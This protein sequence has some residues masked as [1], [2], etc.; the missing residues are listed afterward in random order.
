M[1][2]VFLAKGGNLDDFATSYRCVCWYRRLLPPAIVWWI[3][4]RGGCHCATLPVSLMIH[5]TYLWYVCT[6]KVLLLALSSVAPGSSGTL[7]PP[8]H[9]SAPFH[10]RYH[11]Q[12]PPSSHRQ[13]TNLLP[14]TKSDIWDQIH[15]WHPPHPTFWPHWLAL[16]QFHYQ[17]SPFLSSLSSIPSLQFQTDNFSV[18]PIVPAYLCNLVSFSSHS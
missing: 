6:S 11:F 18:N 7:H 4:W 2:K 3:S 16:F 15:L 9:W 8:C 13:S 1:S 14:R 5:T 10:F 17:I 12:F